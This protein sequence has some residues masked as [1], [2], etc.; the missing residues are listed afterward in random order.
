L[1]DRQSPADPMSGGNHRTE[2]ATPDPPAR[3]T[4][5]KNL[6]S[7]GAADLPPINFISPTPW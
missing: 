1:N 6:P 2:R 7:K 4:R 5:F 3:V